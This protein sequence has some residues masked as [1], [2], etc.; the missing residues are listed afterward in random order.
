MVIVG[1]DDTKV[2]TVNSSK[3]Y[4]RGS[5]SDK[6]AP[7][8]AILM[9]LPGSKSLGIDGEM[10]RIQEAEIIICYSS[11]GHDLPVFVG[12]SYGNHLIHRYHQECEVK[13]H[14]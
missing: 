12:I 8:L 5:P 14:I 4:R 13:H 2:G 7:Y 9:K 6:Q 3:P 10:A 11:W 1:S